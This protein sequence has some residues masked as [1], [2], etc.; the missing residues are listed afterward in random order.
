ME[1]DKLFF[2]ID[3]F[4][5]DATQ[6]L[7]NSLDGVIDEFWV[8]VNDSDSYNY[9]SLVTEIH[10]EVIGYNSGFAYACNR[11]L[12]LAKRNNRKYIVQI[13]N[14]AFFRESMGLKKLNRIM[15]QEND[16][17]IASP[18]VILETND[19]EFAGSHW[20]SG[21][22]LCIIKTNKYIHYDT[23]SIRQT[24]FI[25]GACFIASVEA[26]QNVDGFDCDYFAYR[27]EHDLVFRLRQK[28]LKAG[29]ITGIEVTHTQ[30]LTSNNYSELKS[31]LLFRGQGLFA[32]KN[33]PFLLRHFYFVFLIVK[34]SI[35]FIVS[36]NNRK[37]RSGIIK[38]FLNCFLNR[39][40]EF[41]I[42]EEKLIFSGNG[43]WYNESAKKLH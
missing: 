25:T 33:Y 24:S 17:A 38:G 35:K 3:F 2:T 22:W 9:L 39:T 13:N 31:F 32:K 43:K 40:I 29:Y 30:S 37:L 34:Q 14:D 7:I 41:D 5:R 4:N 26:L 19:I 16:L 15:F 8:I 36:T 21:F 11:A 23:C 42:H 27:E 20:I 10:I 1:K 18:S 6:R 28:G 12:L